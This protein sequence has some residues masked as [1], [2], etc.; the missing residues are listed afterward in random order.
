MHALAFPAS[1][2][3]CIRKKTPRQDLKSTKSTRENDSPS[4]P[5]ITASKDL[6]SA[7]RKSTNVLNEVPPFLNH[8]TIRTSQN[9]TNRLRRT[10]QCLLQYP[11]LPLLPTQ[12]FSEQPS[13][14][15]AL[16]SSPFRLSTRNTFPHLLKLFWAAPK[17]MLEKAMT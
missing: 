2:V 3:S 4:Y 5:I 8:Q 7:R 9:K 6:I 12:S 10:P 17:N 16:C 11:S 13:P 15:W 14:L 1:G